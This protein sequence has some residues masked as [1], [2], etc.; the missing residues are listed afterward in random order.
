VRLVPF[1]QDVED[2]TDAFM[3]IYQVLCVL[4][5]RGTDRSNSGCHFRD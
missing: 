5:R 4:E 1:L 3:V 2:M